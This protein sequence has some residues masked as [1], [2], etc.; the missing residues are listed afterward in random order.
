[1]SSR[2]AIFTERTGWHSEQLTAALADRGCL[3]RTVSLQRC[4]I[5]LTADT[6]GLRIPGFE[7]AL[8]DGVIVRGVPGGT[9]ENIVLCLDVL[10]ALREIGVPVQN[11]AR[12][13][14]RTV[15]KAMTSLI[16]NQA[17]IRTPPAWS[18]SDL[19]RVEDIVRSETGKGNTL[20][21]K[22]LFG[23][24]GAGL[25]RIANVDDLP[26]ADAYN[27]VYYLQRYVP[28]SATA[29]R[30][31]RVFVIGARAVAAMRREGTN[32][33]TNVAN[34]ARCRAASLDDSMGKLAEHACRTLECDYAGVDVI[35]DTKGRLWVVEV[36][37]IP[38][39][40]GLQSVCSADIAGLLADTLVDRIVG[41]ATVEAAG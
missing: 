5:D 4:G 10:H 17:G 39:W 34:G 18:F 38:A 37:S 22:P 7:N 29:W 2:I 33:I 3:S 35:R 41:E 23:S 20:V 21:L 15:D 13:I 6:S 32:W 14:E 19:A 24:Q 16:L 40:Q 27:G 36:N 30:D 12:A 25:C 1:M 26:S 11:D 9:L 8:P 31:W 28:A